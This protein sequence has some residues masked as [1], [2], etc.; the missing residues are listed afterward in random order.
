MMNMPNSTASAVQL[1]EV[2]ISDSVRTPVPTINVAPRTAAEGLWNLSESIRTYVPMKTPMT[3]S[4]VAAESV[5]PQPSLAGLKSPLGDESALR[6]V[7][8]GFHLLPQRRPH[9]R[10]VFSRL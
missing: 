4:V 3:M 6:E 5:K 7:R 1:I 9:S 10:V 2:K 8:V